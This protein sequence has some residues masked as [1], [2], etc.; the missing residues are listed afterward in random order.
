MI[1][2]IARTR[3]ALWVLAIVCPLNVLVAGVLLGMG[4]DGWK[5]VAA[6]ISLILGF[7]GC[8]ALIMEGR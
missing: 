2:I 3:A 1:R 8:V 5:Q 7:R 6:I 4:V